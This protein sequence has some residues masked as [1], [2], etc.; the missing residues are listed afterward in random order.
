M[1]GIDIAILVIFALCVLLGYYKGFLR[2]VINV[3]SLF[4]SWLLAVWIGPLF[5]SAMMKTNWLAMLRYYID[6]AEYIG[7]NMEL[8]NMPLGQ[9]D[10][11]Q[12]QQVMV[13]NTLPFPLPRLFEQNM[14]TEAFASQ[15]VHTVGGTITET[16]LRFSLNVLCFMLAFCLIRLLISLAVSAYDYVYRFP[17]LRSYDS[18]MGAGFGVI[19]AFFMLFLLAMLLPVLLTALQQMGPSNIINVKVST[20]LQES[21]LANFFYQSNFLLNLIKG[22]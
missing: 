16:V 8:A 17:V 1:N 7:N 6:G 3:V 20:I 18:L 14:G 2:T 12:M 19:H 5:R 13:E 11:G 22:I 10:A 4:V 9:L 15:G 21:L